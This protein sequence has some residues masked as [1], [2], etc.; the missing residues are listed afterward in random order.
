MGCNLSN[1]TVNSIERKKN[2]IIK[3]TDIK[4]DI[5]LIKFI[6]MPSLV[7][8]KFDYKTR[9]DDTTQGPVHSWYS[10]HSN[11]HAQTIRTAHMG[12]HLRNAVQDSNASI[13][14]SE[15]QLP[16]GEKVF[17]HWPFLD[18]NPRAKLVSITCYGYNYITAVETRFEVPGDENH[19]VFLHYGTMHE[20]TK[21]NEMHQEKLILEPNEYIETVNC[22]CNAEN[23]RI[24]SLT[25]GRL[26]SLLKLILTQYSDILFEFI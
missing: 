23:H 7:S 19:I 14:V 4:S 18:Q 24:R 9:T 26:F 8:G 15:N 2:D 5:Q 25:L 21:K 6:K 20:H 13:V 11:V 22:W 1:K 12:T 17:D 16:T 3:M 10:V